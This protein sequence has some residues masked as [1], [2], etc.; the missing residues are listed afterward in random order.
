MDQARWQL[1]KGVLHE[2]MDLESPARS[3]FLDLRCADD[4]ELRDQVLMYLSAEESHTFLNRHIVEPQFDQSLEGRTI[5]AYKIISQLGRGGMSVVYLA[6]RCDDRFQKEVAVKVLRSSMADDRAM[7]HFRRER[8]ILANLDHPYIARLIDGGETAEGLPYIVMD[9]VQGKTLLE[10]CQSEHLSISQRLALLIKIC[11]GVHFAHQNLV[12]HRDLKPSNILVSK[13]GDPKLLDFGIARLIHPADLG[14]VTQ[15]GQR[16]FTPDYA[17][18]EQILGK[19]MGTTSDIYSLGVLLYELLV[20]ERPFS[21]RSKQDMSWLQEDAV[22]PSEKVSKRSNSNQISRTGRELRGDLDDIVMKCLRPE[23]EGRYAS[24]ERLSEDLSSYL[25]GYP[26]AARKGRWGYRFGKWVRRNKLLMTASFILAL[27]ASIFLFVVFRQYQKT[28]RERVSKEH[29]S[30]FLIDV[31]SESD[32]YGLPGEGQFKMNNGPARGK[33]L[34]ANHPDALTIHDILD[35]AAVMIG[36]NLENE[37]PVRAKLME[38]IGSI[39]VSNHL[40][41]QARDLLEE[42]LAIRL[43]IY[44]EHHRETAFSYNAL[45]QMAFQAGR[46]DE[47]KTY[48]LKCLSILEPGSDP[49]DPKIIEVKNGLGLSYYHSDQFGKA[50]E[51]FEGLAPLELE[52]QTR[53][54]SVITYNHLG[55]TH[56]KMGQYD[57][58][59]AAYEKAL[60]LMAENDGV[61]TPIYA[62]LLDNLGIVYRQTG[63]FDQA[64]SHFE[65][66]LEIKRLHFEEESLEIAS[67]FNNLGLLHIRREDFTTAQ[68]Y[69]SR[70]LRIKEAL[71]PEDHPQLGNALN[72]MAMVYLQLNRFSEV[73][74]IHK[75]ALEIRTRV[76]GS[77]SVPVAITLNNL[78]NLYIRQERWEDAAEVNESSGDLFLKLLGPD[79]PH[80]AHSLNSRAQIYRELG[81]IDEALAFCEEAIRIRKKALQPDHPLLQ[82]SLELYEAL[83]NEGR[84]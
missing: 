57:Q 16:W 17:S 7:E 83:E 58:A 31:L 10:F 11:A 78:A 45:A 68:D 8:Q 64:Q 82:A 34:G 41:D 13:D 18:P 62:S 36:E 73:E 65:R 23:P 3:A 2:V 52:G 81:R 72:N 39:Y 26:V 71:L 14:E 56:Y 46:F 75:R 61:Q 48:I 55:L 69:L 37:P 30:A 63:K 66:G 1:I 49:T 29:L 28:E 79:H 25:N 32:P 67:S 70:S 76:Y 84:L 51:G 15:T 6:A 20:G 80:L 47:A 38:V 12:I 54:V 60:E 24:V 43:K 9:Y 42:S 74:Q 27:M 50:L 4:P 40:P 59:T 53:L 21:L 19:P 35:K 22:A 33:G 44:G 77:E 5:G